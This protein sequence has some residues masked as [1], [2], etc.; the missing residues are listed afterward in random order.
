VEVKLLGLAPLS[1]R[2]PSTT[3]SGSLVNDSELVPR[4]RIEGREEAF[5][6]LAGSLVAS[7]AALQA[8]GWRPPLATRAGLAALARAAS[9]A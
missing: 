8:L 1:K 3:T 5:E 4:M 9:D 6:R 2:I 7:P